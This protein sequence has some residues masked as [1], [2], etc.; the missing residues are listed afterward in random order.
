M[1]F[2]HPSS[3][4]EGIKGGDAVKFRLTA[5]G[6]TSGLDLARVSPEDWLLG[7]PRIKRAPQTLPELRWLWDRPSQG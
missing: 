3:I 6:R 1:F 5:G 2:S 7:A 4:C